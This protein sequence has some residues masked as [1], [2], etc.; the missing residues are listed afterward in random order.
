[1]KNSDKIDRYPGEGVKEVYTNKGGGGG[2][3]NIRRVSE[4]FEKPHPLRLILRHTLDTLKCN[5]LW[6]IK[7]L[8]MNL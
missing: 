6:R 1:L 2:P 3:K 5:Q 7:N 8:K 4:F